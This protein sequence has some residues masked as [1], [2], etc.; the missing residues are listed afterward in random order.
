MRRANTEGTTQ[1]TSTLPWEVGPTLRLLRKRRGLSL[2][3]LELQTRK[4]DPQ[5]KGIKVAQLGR[6]ENLKTL[7]DLRE[8]FLLCRALD[9]DP[10]KSGNGDE[11]VPW[12]VVRY[13]QAV[14]RLPAAGQRLKRK[15]EAHT[16]M[17][18]DKKIYRYIPLENDPDHIAE[19]E[20]EG[21][22][23]PTM[24]KHLFEVGRASE[25]VMREGLDAH[26]GEEVIVVLEG[27]LEFW[28]RQPK[29]NQIARLVLKPGDTLQY[30]SNIFHAY[31]AAGNSEF[32][33]AIFVYA[34]AQDI[35][36][37]G[38]TKPPIVPEL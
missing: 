22:L 38:G 25:D 23:E 8:V 21:K 37:S 10:L 1:L 13:K 16:F 12:F 32:A 29:K 7:P 4:L 18:K 6:I 15:D 14:D 34:R 20:A 19:G 36:E 17:I 3:D 35:V 31:R 33:R 26:D 30:R 9:Y 11:A 2:Q 27:E 24:R 5:R 28:C